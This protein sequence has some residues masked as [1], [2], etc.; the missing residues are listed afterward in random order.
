MLPLMS[1]V[2][3]MGRVYEFFVH[4]R[5]LDYEWIAVVH[6]FLVSMRGQLRG[7]F[8]PLLSVWIEREGSQTK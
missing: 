4:E 3:Q 1:D 7:W 2:S 8:C 6:Q 5:S